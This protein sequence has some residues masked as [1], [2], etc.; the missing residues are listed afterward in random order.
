M[1]RAARAISILIAASYVNPA[2]GQTSPA[3][4]V[5]ELQNVVEY[6]VDTTDLSKWGSSPN[7]T[8]GSI[9]QG[10]GVGCAGVPII[11]YGDIVS[12]N[13]QPARGTYAVRGTS[14]CMSPTPTPGAFTIADTTWNS[15]R[16]ETFEILQSDGITSVGT[17]MTI[18][19]NS[20]SPTPPGP[21]A[22]N[23]N[24]T[25]VGGTGAFFGVRGQKGGASNQLSSSTPERTASITEDPSRRRQNGGGHIAS[26]LYVIPMSRPDIV[27]TV[28]GPAVAHSSDFSLVS[29][30]K[31]AAAG[32]ILSLFATGLGPTRTVLTPGQP[33]PS[34]PLAVVNSPIDVT[35]N[36]KSAEVLAAVGYPGAVDGYQVNFR[37]PSDV[38]TGTVSIQI[39]TA[40][41][42]GA[43]VS[44]QVR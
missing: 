30:A 34:S 37:V 23:Q 33:F 3:T 18:G 35:V 29:S 28:N 11:G 2:R 38:T 7:I 20:G 6:Q 9:A 1:S 32:E 5:V 16:D 36:G 12:V 40:W 43:P 19:L 10:K 27:V 24:Y 17:I 21:R 8:Q 41:I 14:V 39:S 15:R 25:I 4:L 26:I 42:P 31:P 13:G 44:I 22:G